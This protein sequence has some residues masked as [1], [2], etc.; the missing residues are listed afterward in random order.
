M[1]PEPVMSWKTTSSLSLTPMNRAQLC[2]V[3]SWVFNHMQKVLEII[4]VS[5]NL[6]DYFPHQHWPKGSRI[7]GKY[8]WL[9]KQS[10]RS[11]VHMKNSCV[12][13]IFL[14][15]SPTFGK[16]FL[17]AV[18]LIC[19]DKHYTSCCLTAVKHSISSSTSEF[20]AAPTLHHHLLTLGEHRR[21]CM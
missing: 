7:K 16:P 13:L 20:C 9:R 3:V 21:E 8:F 5:L 6:K 2:S 19:S 1:V 14:R 4:W 10:A 11:P 17:I 15:S 18:F 12:N